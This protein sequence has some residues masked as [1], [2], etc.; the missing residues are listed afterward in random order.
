MATAGRTV[1][2]S[3][4]TVA[5]S[6]AGLMVFAAPLMRAI[7]AAGV[8]VVLVAV[9]VA[10]TLVPALCTVAARRLMGRGLGGRAGRGRV[11]RLARAGAA[12]PVARS[13]R[14]SSRSLLAA[15]VPRA[16]ACAP[17]PRAPSCC[18]PAAR[19]RVFFDDLARDYP[20][21]TSPDVTVVGR[22]LARRR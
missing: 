21:A 22:D 18:R 6:L 2:F 7:G 15:A 12:P 19:Q 8:S 14:R 13:S 1:L 5:I 17:R 10:L 16:R 20:A 3:G 11:R 9:L 4:L